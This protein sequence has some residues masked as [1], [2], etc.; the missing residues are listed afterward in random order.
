MLVWFFVAGCVLWP[1]RVGAQPATDSE[2]M[3]LAARSLLLDGQRMGDRV[4]VV[5]ERGHVLIS[6]NLGRSWQQQ[7]VPTR[8]T[9]T[10][11]FFVDATQGWVAGHDGVILATSDGGNR[12]HKVYSN[13]D[14]ERPILDLWFHD[15]KHGFAVGA[16]GL[17]L[18]TVDGGRTWN[19]VPFAPATLSMDAFSAWD[20]T[21]EEEFWSIDFHLNQMAATSADRLYLSAEAGNLYRSDDGARSWVRL[22]TPYP[23]SF[24]GSLP[25]DKTSLLL[26][27]LRGHLFR[28][29]DAGVNWQQ[30]PTGTQSTLNDGIR[31]ADGRIVLVGQAGAVLVSEDQGASFVLQPQADRL[32]IAK[33]LEM[34]DGA[35]LLVG[36]QGV[37][38]IRLDEVRAEE[39]P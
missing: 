22:P 5:G 10:S 21:G 38:R 19:E 27:G 15:H 32:G 6:G 36:E 1:P 17:F 29:T 11:V 4:V 34:A 13:P 14:D 3:P 12:W 9:L 20:Q 2:L 35:L 25:L 16:Y 18:A 26:Y 30:V 24:Y 33:V 8:A 28:S 31:L 39:E 7:T 37:R 23:G